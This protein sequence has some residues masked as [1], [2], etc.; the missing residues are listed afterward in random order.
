ML[1]LNFFLK[2]KPE[3]WLIW[4]SSIIEKA[5]LLIFPLRN[6]QIK[7]CSVMKQFA[8]LRKGFVQQILK[9]FVQILIATLAPFFEEVVQRSLIQS[10][11]VWQSNFS[12][13][14][15]ILWSKVSKVNFG[16]TQ[17]SIY[18]SCWSHLDSFSISNA[19]IKKILG[20]L[21]NVI[22]AQKKNEKIQ[23]QGKLGVWLS[24]VCVAVN[25]A[26]PPVHTEHLLSVGCW[27]E[28][29]FL[30]FGYLHI[31]MFAFLHFDFQ[32]LFFLQWRLALFH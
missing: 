22:D 32:F 8:N 12:N 7:F 9:R 18:N 21:K 25:R 13:K 4:L 15:I 26:E 20:V 31:C 17:Q 16:L 29:I 14:V 28:G 5:T 6:C 11:F 27:G 1:W 3:F 23:S 10:P 30:H 24:I 2:L 19:D